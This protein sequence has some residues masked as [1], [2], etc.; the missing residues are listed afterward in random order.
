MAYGLHHMALPMRPM[1]LRDHTGIMWQA[2]AS[3]PELA[4]TSFP[5]ALALG[6][7]GPTLC[8]STPRCGFATVPV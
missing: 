1:L 5:W 4:K 2:A 7:A 6:G 3:D 8:A